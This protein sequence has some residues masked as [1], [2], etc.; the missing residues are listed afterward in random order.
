MGSL[1]TGGLVTAA[2][3][4][5]DAARAGRAVGAR[6]LPASQVRAGDL[7]LGPDATVVRVA[8]NRRLGSGRRRIRYTDPATGQARPLDAR[9]DAGGLPAGQ[10]LAV[11]LRKVPASAVRLSVPEPPEPPAGPVVIDGGAP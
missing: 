11:F 5:A 8:S 7:V 6:L 9:T 10:K 3:T 4:P 1:L 2:S